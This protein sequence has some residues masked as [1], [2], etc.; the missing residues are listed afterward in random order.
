MPLKT[1]DL[2]T[3]EIDNDTFEEYLASLADV[4]SADKYHLLEHNCNSSVDRSPYLIYFQADVYVL[5]FTNDVASFL[6]GGGIPQ[7]VIDLPKQFLST[8]FGSSLRPMIDNMF[9]R[10]AGLPE[11]VA[12][13]TVPDQLARQFANSPALSETLQQVAQAAVRSNGNSNVHGAE[14]LEAALTVAT[15]LSAFQSILSGNKCVSGQ[16]ASDEILTLTSQ[17][18]L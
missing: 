17:V 18:L 15:N 6:T 4:Y 10:R 7:D 9:R 14:V 12:S 1:I 11:A 13:P 3:T 2:G 8:P 5:S 16:H